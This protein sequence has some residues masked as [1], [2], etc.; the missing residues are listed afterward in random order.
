M[1]VSLIIA[2]YLYFKTK[3]N[4][5]YE[6][7]AELAYVCTGRSSVFVINTV[8]PL[9]CFLIIVMYS[10]LFGDISIS[11]YEEYLRSMGNQESDTAFDEIMRSRATY[12][13]ILFLVLL[14]TVG[15]KSMSELK[16]TSY[17]LFSGV[18][19]LISI[20]V[21]KLFQQGNQV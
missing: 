17:I 18:I 12:S 9:A 6:S 10:I 7:L 16:I 19:L 15:K 21:M 3:D 11:L 4:L 20:F 5:G 8:F 14:P 1:S 13:F 2:T